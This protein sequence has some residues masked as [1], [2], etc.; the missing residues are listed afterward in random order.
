MLDETIDE[1]EKAQMRRVMTIQKVAWFIIVKWMWVFILLFVLLGGGF[2]AWLMFK[3]STS[4]SRF[5][6]TTR[7]LFSPQKVAQIENISDRQLMSV[8]ERPSLKSRVGERLKLPEA[9]R[10]QLSGEMEIEQERRPSNLFTLTVTAPS[11]QEAIDRA[12]AYAEVLVDEYVAYRSVD[13]ERKHDSIEAR[14][15]NILG[16][17]AENEAEMSKLKAKTGVAAP[18]EMLSTLNSLISDQRRN[19]SALAVSMANEELR[20]QKF[21]GTVGGLGPAVIANASAI[22]RRSESIAKLDKEIAE[23]RTM[24]TDINPKVAGKLQDREEQVKEMQAFLK[25]KGVKAL[26]IDRIDEIEKAA[27]ELAACATRMEAL[28]ERQRVLEQELKDNEKKAEQL[29]A[30]VPEYERLVMRYNDLERS[31]RKMSDDM[32]DITYLMSALRND[33]RQVER[34]DM[35]ADRGGLTPKTAVL[36]VAGAIICVGTLLLWVVLVEFTFGKVRGGKEL[37]VYGNMTFIGSLPKPRRLSTS[38]AKEILGVVALKLLGAEAPRGIMLVCRL[39]GSTEN[40]EFGEVLSYTASMSGVRVFTLNVV[41][42]DS[43]TPPAGAQQMVGVVRKDEQ[44][45]FPVLNRYALAPTELEM[46]KAD[47]AELRNSF[48]TVFIRMEGGF[49]RGG[50]FFDQLLSASETAVLMVGTARTPRS[51]VGYVR[52][53]VE[54]AGKPMLVIATDASV[55]TVRAEMDV[56]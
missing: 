43:F 7:L 38:E 46:L 33:L 25:E 17:L 5:E 29:T 9:Q 11:R 49:R 36:A 1:L 19:L 42:Q 20:R 53:H 2:A 50:S 28:A 44:G 48:D 56:R 52:R 31:A 47:L 40:A 15:K 55:R 13:L 6:A 32:N 30:L 23:L 34:A 22:R 3:S 39:P 24:Y 37:S 41:S 18:A 12:N 21:G 26:D 51:W 35:A 16:Q 45:W 14:R 27:G 8:I 10:G 54:A 4:Q